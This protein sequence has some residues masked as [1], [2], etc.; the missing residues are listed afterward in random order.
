MGTWYWYRQRNCNGSLQQ[1][2]VSQAW[3][4]SLISVIYGFQKLYRKYKQSRGNSR[5]VPPGCFKWLFKQ[6]FTTTS[7]SQKMKFSIEDFFSK[8]DQIRWKLRIWSYLLKKSWR[9]NLCSVQSS[10]STSMETQRLRAIAYKVLK[11]LN[12]NPNPQNIIT[13][14]L[15]AYIWNSF[16]ENIKST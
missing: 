10:G 9:E 3:W 14:S 8:R 6:L 7:T 11:N 1:I 16:P 12:L 4:P 5:K 15:G 2:F 13:W